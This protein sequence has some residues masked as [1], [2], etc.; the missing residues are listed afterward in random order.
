MMPK[1]PGQKP[2]GYL[3]SLFDA[4]AAKI[5]FEP[6]YVFKT[7]P[8]MVS[9]TLH[10]Q[11]CEVNVESCLLLEEDI[12]VPVNNE[13]STGQRVTNELSCC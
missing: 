7:G 4:V 3:V 5:G 6:F 9:F 12:G 13:L 11:S 2:R 8:Q 10:I 1:Q